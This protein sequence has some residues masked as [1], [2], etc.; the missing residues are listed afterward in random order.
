[1]PGGSG[2]VQLARLPDLAD[3]GFRAFVRFPA[4]WSRAQRGHYPVDEEFL[5]IEGELALNERTYRKGDWG[6][7]PAG[8]TRTL[9]ASAS[10]C[11]VYA[12]FGGFP[13]WIAGDSVPP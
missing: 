9:L 13:R 7:V 8:E 6:F 2:P 3:G 12:R 5:V 10:G 1:M 4:G 11:V